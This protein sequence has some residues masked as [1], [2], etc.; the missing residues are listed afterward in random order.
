MP[1]VLACLKKPLT[2]V[3]PFSVMQMTMNLLRE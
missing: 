3:E 2:F 1:L